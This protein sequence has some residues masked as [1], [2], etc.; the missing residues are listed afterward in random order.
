MDISTG[1]ICPRANQET[2]LPAQPP[3]PPPNPPNKIEVA[4]FP[5]D[6]VSNYMYY[7]RAS[8]GPIIPSM[9]APDVTGQGEDVIIDNSASQCS[10]YSLVTIEIHHQSEEAMGNHFYRLLNVFINV[11]I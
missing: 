1:E 8:S 9:G 7:T 11:N 5:V 4:I 2:Q 3:P 10:Q 6:D